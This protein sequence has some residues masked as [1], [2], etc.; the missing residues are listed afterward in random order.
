M[1]EGIHPEQV[2]ELLQYVPKFSQKLFGIEI[3]WEKYN[4]QGKA[5]FMLDL[6]TLQKIGVKLMVAL[7]VESTADFND[8]AID[9]DLK[10]EN[11]PQEAAE[12]VMAV[13]Q[14]G[15]IAIITNTKPQ[16]GEIF[17]YYSEHLDLEKIIILVANESEN[18]FQ[19][20]LSYAL[21]QW[22]AAAVDYHLE[23]S[24]V[25]QLVKNGVR[26]IHFL[27]VREQSTVLSELFSNEGTGLMVF[28]DSYRKIRQIRKEDIPEVLTL[29]GK[30][31]RTSH[32]VPREYE[33]IEA[34]LA[35]YY[36]YQ[37][38]D[39]LVGCIALHI[40]DKKIAEIACLFVKYG[41]Q[42]R[43]Y[44][45]GLVEHVI[46]VAKEKQLDSVFALTNSALGFFK[47]KMGFDSAEL[48]TLPA[49]RLKKLELSGRESYAFQK[50]LF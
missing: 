31:V 39:N 25:Q 28:N 42:S 2:R 50:K 6:L 4:D 22:D 33:E 20:G 26:R 19:D 24:P 35:D 49:E 32:L 8:W 16:K 5:D 30:S 34:Q 38:D 41:H 21:S 46:N 10:L 13:V 7:P 17:V 12:A 48:K 44:G 47:T 29:I 9:F 11:D 1:L 43:G 36:V 14:R 23:S 18:K 27:G 37:I 15:Q 45:E 3:P 40:Y